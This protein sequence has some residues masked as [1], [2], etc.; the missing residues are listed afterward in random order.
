MS[1]PSPR[2]CDGDLSAITDAPRSDTDTAASLLRI[3]FTMDI[4]ESALPS[5]TF[6]V[7]THRVERF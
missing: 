4:L 7:G 5:T 2:E 1:C 3:N 6:S